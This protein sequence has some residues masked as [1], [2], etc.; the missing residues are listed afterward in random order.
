M[1]YINQKK[2]KKDMLPFPDR[3]SGSGNTYFYF[4]IFT[5]AYLSCMAMAIHG[6]TS[7]LWQRKSKL[8]HIPCTYLVEQ[9]QQPI[10]DDFTRE[11]C[12]SLNA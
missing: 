9:A 1:C 8:A 7:P 11:E 2:K 10:P 4:L 3:S 12:L 5:N 6:I